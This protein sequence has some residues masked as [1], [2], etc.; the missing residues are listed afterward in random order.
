MGNA[1]FSRKFQLFVGDAPENTGKP[2]KTL[3]SHGEMEK[4]RKTLVDFTCGTDSGGSAS[5]GTPCTTFCKIREA[6]RELQTRRR[7]ALTGTTMSNNYAE[8]WA[9]LDF[10]KVGLEAGVGA[11]HVMSALWN[12]TFRAG[13][14]IDAFDSVRLSLEAQRKSRQ[15]QLA[16][17]PK[18]VIQ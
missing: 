17:G 6:A 16:V 8:L 13:Q 1:T 5:C 3:G 14:P 15:Q 9:M 18:A 4:H 11:G 10:V 7:F 12:S 2:W